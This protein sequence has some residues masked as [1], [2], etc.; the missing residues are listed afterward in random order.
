MFCLDYNY[1]NLVK[2]ILVTNGC[3]NFHITRGLKVYNISVMSSFTFGFIIL[4][5]VI[6]GKSSFKVGCCV[7]NAKSNNSCVII[8]TGEIF[9]C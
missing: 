3:N 4:C 5:C 2:L 7:W 6:V 1:E 9:D 8:L